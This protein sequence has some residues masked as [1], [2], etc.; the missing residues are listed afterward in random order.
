MPKLE[1]EPISSTL[2]SF[3]LEDGVLTSPL[4][5]F[6]ASSI[7][8]SGC[9]Y[10]V[11]TVVNL[12]TFLKAVI[13]FKIHISVSTGWHNKAQNDMMEGSPDTCPCNPKE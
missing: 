12:P 11:E 8:S 5:C 10:K 7:I 6:V 13:H 1:L 2:S 3:A 9:T 4:E